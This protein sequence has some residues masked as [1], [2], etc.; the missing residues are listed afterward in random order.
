MAAPGENITAH[1]RTRLSLLLQ[2]PSRQR[3]RLLMPARSTVHERNPQKLNVLAH[4]EPP[5]RWPFAPH[6]A[7]ITHQRRQPK[8]FR[9]RSILFRLDICCPITMAHAIGAGRDYK[10]GD[11]RAEGREWVRIWRDGVSCHWEGFRKGLC[12]SAG[13]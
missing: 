7:S 1:R 13:A 2:H 5:N 6:L 10:V 3:M 11:G 8:R 4:D 12:P 9:F